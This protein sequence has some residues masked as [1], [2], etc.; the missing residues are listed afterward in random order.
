MLSFGLVALIPNVIRK[1]AIEMQLRPQACVLPEV[2]FRRAA[3]AA[4]GAFSSGCLV[5]WAADGR[6]ARGV[7]VREE[8]A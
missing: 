8:D 4:I 6:Y 1:V 3:Q 5:Y 2:A 7:T